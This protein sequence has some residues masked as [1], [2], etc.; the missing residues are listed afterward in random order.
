VFSVEECFQWEK[1]E[2]DIVGDCEVIAV[3]VAVYEPAG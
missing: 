1:M 2:H 3:V